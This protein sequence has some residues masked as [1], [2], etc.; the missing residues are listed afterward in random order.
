LARHLDSIRWISV[1]EYVFDEVPP[2][3]AGDAAAWPDVRV[4]VIAW[5]TLL[6]IEE[7]AGF[8]SQIERT[9]H[10]GDYAY[11]AIQW[12]VDESEL[13]APLRKY[14]PRP[15]LAKGEVAILN[16]LDRASP[17]PL[18]LLLLAEFN[19]GLDRECRIP[20]LPSWRRTLGPQLRKLIRRGLAKRPDGRLRSGSVITEAGRDFLAGER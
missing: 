19:L 11:R 4:R 18:T 13:E 12:R 17:R 8:K 10:V 3:V 5:E 16:A 15:V 14:K 20:D 9:L 1:D 2:E 6:P 7:Q